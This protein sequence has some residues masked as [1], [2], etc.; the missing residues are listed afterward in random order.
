M[1]NLLL[2]VTLLEREFQDL[3]AA[4]PELA[5]DEQLRA[6]TIEGETN[7]EVVLSRIAA[8][9]LDAKAIAAAQ[10]SRIDDLKA[11]QAGSERRGEAMRKLALRLLQAADLPR[12]RLPEATLTVAKGRDSVE[13][14]DEAGLPAWA[15]KTDVTK[16]VSKSAIKEAIDGGLS[17][18]GA[19]IKTGEPTLQVR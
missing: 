12:V 9:I 8:Q 18:P 7:A 16:S 10:Q 1:S 6:D 2:E 3:V 11:R 15:W 5:E 13:I 19:R 17:V 4:Y 14:T